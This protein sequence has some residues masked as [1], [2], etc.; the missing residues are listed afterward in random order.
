MVDIWLEDITTD[1]VPPTLS[2]AERIRQNAAK[3]KPKKQLVFTADIFGSPK[4]DSDNQTAL[5][6]IPSRSKSRELLKQALSIEHAK[7]VKSEINEE[8]DQEIQDEDSESESEEEEDLPEELKTDVGKACVD[9]L[10][11]TGAE[12]ELTEE[13]IERRIYEKVVELRLSEDLEEIKKIIR[14]ITGQWRSGRLRFTGEGEEGLDRAFEGDEKERKELNAKRQMRKQRKARQIAERAKK[15]T[16]ESISQLIEKAMWVEAGNREDAS[17]SDVLRGEIAMMS[18]HDPRKQVLERLEMNAF[19]KEQR[20]KDAMKEKR[21][22]IAR[23]MTPLKRTESESLMGPSEIQFKA[24]DIG[25]K[26]AAFSFIVREKSS[27]IFKPR[28]EE[29]V[30]PRRA[31]STNAALTAFLTREDTQ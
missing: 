22:V 24:S 6:V 7:F 19:L 13:E 21:S 28:K 27:E 12:S 20:A 14:I 1:A 2:L 16:S 25:K 11:K 4:R 5:R 9:E 23:N 8:G 3:A 26:Q 18:E 31:Q 29:I 15:L 10:K 30:L 17:A